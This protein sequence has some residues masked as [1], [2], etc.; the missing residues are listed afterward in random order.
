MTRPS[1]LARFLLM[2]EEQAPV[3]PV[4]AVRR[5]RRAELRVAGRRTAGGDRH[6]H[7]KRVYD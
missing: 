1:L 6:A 2:P 4:S 7:L 5:H 3:A